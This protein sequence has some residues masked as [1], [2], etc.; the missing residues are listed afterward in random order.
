MSNPLFCRRTSYLHKI[1]DAPKFRIPGYLTVDSKDHIFYFERI[2][3]QNNTNILRYRYL[4][5]DII[6][7]PGNIRRNA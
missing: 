4:G 3:D 2:E 6:E 5:M 7:K 1:I